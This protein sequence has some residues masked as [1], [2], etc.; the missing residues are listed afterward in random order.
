MIDGS[1]SS[2]RDTGVNGLRMVIVLVSTA[3]MGSEPHVGW[4]CEEVTHDLAKAQYTGN[5]AKA[6]Y[7][8]AE[9]VDL[10]KWII[11]PT[12]LCGKKIQIRFAVGSFEL[13]HVLML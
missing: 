5:S 13:T 7:L 11:A 4:F 2:V 3:P 6:W 1:S 9:P 12:F 8:L 10:P